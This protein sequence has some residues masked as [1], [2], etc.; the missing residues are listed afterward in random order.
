MSKVKEA[1]SNR[2]RASELRKIMSLGKTCKK[3]SVSRVDVRG[4]N[5]EKRG[6]NGKERN[7]L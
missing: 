3:S 6:W 5:G 7:I 2:C 4:E 1:K